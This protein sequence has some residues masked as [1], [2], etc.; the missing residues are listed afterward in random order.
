MAKRHQSG[1]AML[2][3][4]V[5]L[6]IFTAISVFGTRL[7]SSISQQAGQSG[8]TSTNLETVRKSLVN[9]VAING[10]LPCPADGALDTGVANPAGVTQTCATPDGTVPWATLGISQAMG[11]DGWSRKISY[12]VYQG[13]TGLTIAG[14]ADMTNCKIDPPTPLDPGAAP[15]LC[16]SNHT[17]SPA[18]F[19]AHRSGLSVNDTGSVVG[20]V[21]FV[22]ISHG[23]T[24]YGAWLPGGGRMPLPGQNNVP[25]FTNTQTGTTYYRQAYTDK[26]IPATAINH[27]DDATVYMTMTDLIS[28][29][30]RNARVWALAI[31][32]AAPPVSMSGSLISSALQLTGQSLSG[33]SAGVASLT[34]PSSLLFDSPLLITTDPTM[35][36]AMNSA[37]TALGV[38][39]PSPAVCDD[40]TALLTQPEYISFLLTRN[41]AMKAALV[42][43]Y[44]GGVQQVQLTFKLDGVIVGSPMVVNRAGL[45]DLAPTPSTPF[46]ELVVEPAKKNAA[47]F[48]QSIQ[49][50]DGTASCP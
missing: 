19:F 10:Y 36:L 9:F 33:Q 34:L 25:E 1:S 47:F 7:L 12:R 18:G 22:L 28:Q 13:S 5:I 31:T 6:L 39:A 16:A 17:T 14:G 50:C 44:S 37:K 2:V 21:G 41:T 8:G 38:C 45:T 3:M 46:N 20:Q 26:S 15:S 4:V 24:G 29:A 43:Q 42:L 48:I 40:T 27:F 11:Q 23:E 49:F 30:K 35:V 32:G